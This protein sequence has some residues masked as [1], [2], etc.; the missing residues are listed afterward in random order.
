MAEAKEQPQLP[1]QKSSASKKSRRSAAAKAAAQADGSDPGQVLNEAALP[2]FDDP[3]QQRGHEDID[4]QM[5]QV[6]NEVD[7]GADVSNPEEAGAEQDGLGGD[8]QEEQ[9]LDEVTCKDDKDQQHADE[10]HG[11]GADELRD[12]ENNI[13]DQYDPKQ[14]ANSE[15]QSE[16]RSKKS[17]RTH[18]PKDAAQAEDVP[19]EV[20]REVPEQPLEG[21]EQL[22][23]DAQQMLQHDEGS[24][25]IDLEET[26]NGMQVNN[27][28]DAGR[29][30][31]AIGELDQE[32]VPDSGGEGSRRH[33]SIKKR[34]T[35]RSQADHGGSQDQE[36]NRSDR[37]QDRR[38]EQPRE[39][40]LAQEGRAAERSE[41]EDQEN[42]GLQ[43]EGSPLGLKDLPSLQ[44][45]I[46][47][48]PAAKSFTKGFNEEPLGKRHTEKSLVRDMEKEHDLIDVRQQ[49]QQ[50]T[51][52]NADM[53]RSR[54]T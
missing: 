24:A 14:V 25:L 53:K 18:S 42:E 27:A 40:A 43:A 30:A 3:N 45:S 49:E 31:Q 19:V 23:N 12:L 29:P 33:Q 5:D 10:A 2:D 21:L 22:E 17:Q 37:P 50:H 9:L 51:D 4:E 44:G 54:Y 46:K 34:S 52:Q 6:L 1:S 41:D 11:H 36:R 26:A 7:R 13:M 47:E 8:A 20:A 16:K 28:N 38:S 32:D 15:G 48:D 39:G 35:T